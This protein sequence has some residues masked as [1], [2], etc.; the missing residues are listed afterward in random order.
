MKDLKKEVDMKKIIHR[1]AS[2]GQVDHGWLKSYHTFSFGGYHDASRMNFGLLRILNDDYV[3]AGRGFG[4]HPH[5]N[6]EIVSI[7]LSG[8]LHHQDSTGRDKIIRT[9]DVQIMSAG[10]GIAHSEH[11]ASETESVSF[12]QIW[13]FPKERNIEP[14]YE[15]KTFQIGERENKFQVV[16]S[17]EDANAVWINQE[18]Y[19]SLADLNKGISVDYK[20]KR[21]KNGI[22]VFVLE[23]KIKVVASFYP[24]AEFAKQVGGNN[25]EVVNM[26]PPGAEPHDFEPSPQD[27]VNAYSSNL[28]IF[29]GSGFDPWAE[30]IRPE[31]ENKGVAVINMTEYFDLLKGVE[32]H[33]EAEEKDHEAEETDPHIWLDPVLA[34]KEVEII[35][36]A[37]KK[38]DPINSELYE[39]NA[40]QYLTQLS[41]LDKKY[42]DGLASC[43]LRDLVASH[44]AF[45]YLAK[46]YA[47]N[48]VSIAGFSPE[49]EPSPKRMAEIADLARSKKINYIFFETLV[50]P[51]LA[52]TIAREI[53]AKT[54]VFN[55]IEGLTED[56]LEK[57]A[58]YISVMEENLNNLIE[59]IDFRKHLIVYS[60]LLEDKAKKRG[61]KRASF[62][63][64]K[65]L[66]KVIPFLYAPRMANRRYWYKKTLPDDRSIEYAHRMMYHQMR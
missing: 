30:K 41:V 23:G 48:V 46:R 49:E 9:G 33:E 22:Y 52:E 64:K 61:S 39:S 50:S 40:T 31:L 7:P 51:K 59:I 38:I 8:A 25:V 1:A 32:E 62:F 26:T 28:F 4:K 15:Q 24:L 16:V 21:E 37:L 65:I 2:R 29:N 54:L 18:A 17:P 34:K 42:K 27:I 57:G 5:D 3:E 36:D 20:R 11:N 43:N 45:G 60:I 53:G 13:I 44:G 10:K 12:L 63:F 58:N 35:R 6:M 66:F 55:P 47:L 19:F 14:R 56:E